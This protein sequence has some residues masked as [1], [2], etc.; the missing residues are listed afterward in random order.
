M[1]V[2]F[3][4]KK[5]DALMETSDWL[6]PPRVGD[7]VF[8][9]GDAKDNVQAGESRC[10]QFDAVV[11]EVL[12]F[13]PNKAFVTVKQKATAQSETIP[14]P[15][16]QPEK[17]YSCA[18]CGLTEPHTIATL[19][20]E[21]GIERKREVEADTT[22]EADDAARYWRR[23]TKAYNK[24]AVATNKLKLSEDQDYYDSPF[25]EA[26]TQS[27]GD[28]GGSPGECSKPAPC[29]VSF[30][31]S[32]ARCRR[33]VG[34]TGGHDDSG[35]DNCDGL[36]PGIARTVL[37]LHANGFNTCD[38]GDGVTKDYDCD[39]GYPY[40]HMIAHPDKMVSESKRLFDLLTANGHKVEEFNPDMDTGGPNIQA[41]Y[42]PVNNVATI[43]LF[44]V[45]I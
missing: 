31:Q 32:G 22:S 43:S 9:I 28:G 45:M 42:D 25:F 18:I 19:Y 34:H 6:M 39:L 33:P 21:I 14:D 23:L 16:D 38:S 41:S 11:E 26:E 3:L 29:G 2:T 7:Q 44:N 12:F 37:W 10:F 5:H 1:R 27:W 30:E 20:K 24:H 35:H 4:E 15:G 17:G 13:G 40:V 36:N 8:L